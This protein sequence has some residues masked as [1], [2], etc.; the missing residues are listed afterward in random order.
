MDALKEAV[1][2]IVVVTASAPIWGTLLWEL[3]EG[4]V[5]PW[6]IP[7]DRIDAPAAL[8]LTR[9]GDRAEEMA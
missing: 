1:Y 2:W 5:R 4:V 3:W 8:M 9:Y 6:H 7:R